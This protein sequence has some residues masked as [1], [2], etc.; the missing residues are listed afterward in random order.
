MPDSSLPNFYNLKSNSLQFSPLL[1]RFYGFVLQ[2]DTESYSQLYQDLFALFIFNQK[3]G[4]SFLEFGATN[5][6]ELSNT[7]LLEKKFGWH[8]VLAEPSPQ[9]H[10]QLK[11]NRP[12]ANII[13]DCIY[14]ETGQNLD[15]FVS[16]SGV[17]S[18]LEEFRQSDI[19][20]MHGNT[21]SRNKSGHT[22]K[23]STIS[24]NDVFIKYFNSKPIDFMSVDT[25]GSELLILKNFNF[26]KFGPKCVT[27]EH[28]FTK[29]QEKIDQLFFSNNYRRLFKKYTQFD[30][31]YVKKD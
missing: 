3:K 30:A 23:V 24:L 6:I 5:G 17:L 9:W 28:N 16:K 7:A 26:K 31:W 21:A 11:K 13:T 27:V 18:T 15:F 20:S 14:S 12:E 25:E 22:V 19:S 10:K 2:Y 8:G 1:K 4:G 29:D